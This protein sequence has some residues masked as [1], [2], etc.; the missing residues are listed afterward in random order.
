MSILLQTSAARAITRGESFEGELD[1]RQ[2]DRLREFVADPAPPMRV[3][4]GVRSDAG[5]QAWLEGQVAGQVSLECRSCQS[6]FDW[7]FDFAVQLA[8]VHREEDEERLLERAEPY[9]V[10]ED[11]LML[12]EIVEDEVLLGLPMLPQCPACENARPREQ[13]TKVPVTEPAKTQALAA[14]KNLSLKGRFSVPRK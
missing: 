7:D 12:H 11:R 10:R 2:L 9:L 14:L 6:R 8:L 4:L 13:A 1:P 5:G 3:A